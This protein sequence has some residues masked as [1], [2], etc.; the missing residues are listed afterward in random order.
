MKYT[1][2][3]YKDIT[4]EKL[5]NI[6]KPANS[7]VEVIKALDLPVHGSLYKKIN[8]LIKYYNID[9][10][11]FSGKIWNKGKN[12]FDDS[13]LTKY[14][15]DEIF[16]ENS[17]AA[18]SYVKKLIIQSKLLLYKCDSCKNSGEWLD[19]SLNLQMDHKNG[20]RKDHRLENLRFLCPNC[21]SQTETFCSKNVNYK[22]KKITDEEI[23]YALKE[24]PTI[25]EALNFLGIYNGKNY[26]RVYKLAH[27]LLN[28][29]EFSIVKNKL[30]SLSLNPSA[31]K[32]KKYNSKEEARVS[33]RKIKDRP[34][35][36]KL[37]KMIWEKSTSKIAKDYGLT[38]NSVKNWIQNYKIPNPPVGYWAKHK[39]GHLEECDKIK[40]KLFEKM[41]VE[42]GVE[43]SKP[44]F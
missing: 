34:S 33:S 30:N 32:T 3:N 6:I 4:K 20:N 31:T 38:H 35:K 8:N 17:P 36:E 2:H 43:P 44:N 18:P 11:H 14:T 19:K 28:D 16:S 7:I 10:S 40:E 13:R 15:S 5:E 12:V 25:P 27:T 9:T 26:Y 42:K 39:A 41:V 29:D 21:H 37:L 23:L 24:S 1:R 22:S